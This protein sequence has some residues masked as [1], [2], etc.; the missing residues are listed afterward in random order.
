MIKR[1]EGIGSA[2]LKTFVSTTN[3]LGLLWLSSIIDA[4]WQSVHYFL[5]SCLQIMIYVR[6]CNYIYMLRRLKRT[7]RVLPLRKSNSVLYKWLYL[8]N[9]K[10]IITLHYRSLMFMNESKSNHRP[11]NQCCSR[12]ERYEESAWF[13]SGPAL[14]I[15]AFRHTEYCNL[16]F[17]ETT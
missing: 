11:P 14:A 13:F 7:I 10:R 8:W 3:F 5:I 16:L 17:N 9:S 6:V 2:F 12:A 15:S 4:S 1:W